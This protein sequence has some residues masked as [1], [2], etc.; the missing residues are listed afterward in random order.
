[1]YNNV[2]IQEEN[3]TWMGSNYMTLAGI[4]HVEMLEET[5]SVGFVTGSVHVVVRVQYIQRVWSHCCSQWEEA[6]LNE[7]SEV[8]KVEG[9]ELQSDLQDDDWIRVPSTV[10][11]SVWQRKR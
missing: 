6:T 5:T 8:E 7:V 4:S 2:M 9:K 1:M 10:A 3:R 11:N